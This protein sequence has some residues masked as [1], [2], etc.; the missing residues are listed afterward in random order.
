[1]LYGID[2]GMRAS[3]W[4]P[5][6]TIIEYTFTRATALFEPV[7]DIDVRSDVK[8]YVFSNLHFNDIWWLKP[9]GVRHGLWITVKSDDRPVLDFSCLKHVTTRGARREVYNA[10][11]PGNT[12]T[13]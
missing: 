13:V 12:S 9:V 11:C 10:T 2:P 6:G 3:P 4:L 5:N 7:E 1:V 8:W